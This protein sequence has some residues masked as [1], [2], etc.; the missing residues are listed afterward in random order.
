MVNMNRGKWMQMGGQIKKSN[1]IQTNVVD[2][3]LPAEDLNTI[4]P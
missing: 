4:S 2:R 1:T 3:T